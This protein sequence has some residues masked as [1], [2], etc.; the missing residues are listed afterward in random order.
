MK[1]I[2]L[3]LAGILFSSATAPFAQPD[4][5]RPLERSVSLEVL[6]TYASGIFDEGAAEIVAHDPRR[7][8]LFVVNANDATVDVL[9]MRDPANPLKIGAIDAKDIGA[10]A[11][12]VAVKGDLVAVA[13]ENNDKQA[14]GFVAF[15]RAGNLELLNVVE[16]GALPDMVTFTPNG[17]HVLVANEGEPNDDYT[18]DPE[19]SVSIIDITRGVH[20][21]TVQTAGFDAF[22]K[23]FLTAAGV[24]VFGPGASA[25]QDL[26]PEYITVSRN[27]RTAWVTLQE[28][29]AVAVVDIKNA[30]VT[31]IMPLGTKDHSLPGNELDASN[32]DDGIHIANWPVRGLYLPDAIAS[33]QSRGRTYLVTANEGDARD[34]DGFSEETRVED[35]N[36]DAGAFPD[37]AELQKEENLGRLKTTTTLGDTDGDG[38]IDEIYAYGARSFSIWDSQGHLVYD[39]GADFERIIADRLPDS[40]NSNN[41][42]NDSFD[43]RSDDKGP[44]PEGVT[45]GKILGRTYA[46]VG[47]ERVG[48]IMVYDITDPENARFQ[49]YLNHRDFLSLADAP[50]AGDLGPE[51]LH[52]IPWYASPNR[53]P[54]LVVGNEVSGTTTIY[55]INLSFQ[56]R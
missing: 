13:I 19:G 28:N 32:E 15:Y 31:D 2:K 26:E 47:L 42:D 55:Q 53:R 52:F 23:A 8:R 22:D 33:Y 50:N 38:D 7:Q 21:A 43:S 56:T 46:F 44:E 41:D 24:R 5:P 25:A 14:N 29:N 4:H 45:I 20:R 51:G 34:Y 40:F 6:G 35:L 16:V 39:S 1:A 11:N 48:G 17:R 36:L 18:I 30:E 12:S 9:D 10:S 3:A 27:S 54:L 37:A 49:D